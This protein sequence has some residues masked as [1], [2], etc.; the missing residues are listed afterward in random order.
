MVKI[1]PTAVV[2]SK[3]ELADSVEIGPFCTIGP[4]VK[5]EQGCRVIS[6]AVCDG[7]TE[8]GKNCVIYP[9][10]TI[11]TASQ[12][13]R[14]LT[15]EG[16]LIIGEN[17]TFREGCSVHVGGSDDDDNVTKIGDN[18]W[19]LAY[20]HIAHDCKLG[21][22]IVM[23][24]NASLAGHVIVEDKAIIGGMSGVLQF[25]HIG[26]GCMIGAMSGITKDVIPYGLVMGGVRTGLDGLNL[27]GLQ[28][29]GVSKEEIL[30][31]QKAYKALFN[32]ENGTFATRVEQV[33]AQ[34]E[35]KNNAKIQHIIEF[36]RN[37]SRNNILQPS[38]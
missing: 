24:N 15:N 30:L 2:D 37:P 28:R 38:F 7:H 35:F 1:H 20:T 4:H 36:I 27:I 29:A 32:K 3:A 21:S 34:E 9:F 31:L 5:M 6:H 12:A 10:A 8:I 26:T 14:S 22:G 18:N 17:N 33:A 13:I 23:S 25:T 16:K 11:G 19:F